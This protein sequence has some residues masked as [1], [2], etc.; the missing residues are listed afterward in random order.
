VNKENY[1]AATLIMH[2]IL[3]FLCQTR[4]LKQ[5]SVKVKKK[6]VGDCVER[7]V[8]AASKILKPVH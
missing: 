2:T 3:C 4:I 1:T 8:T 5:A 6:V 7:K